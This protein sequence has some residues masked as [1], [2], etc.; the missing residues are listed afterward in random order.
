MPA[1]AS[2][3]KQHFLKTMICAAVAAVLTLGTARAAFVYDDFPQYSGYSFT[4]ANG[5]EIGNEISVAP[6]SYYSL[7]NFSINVV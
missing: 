6:G 4:A 2:N 3:M 5:Q 7:T 1:T